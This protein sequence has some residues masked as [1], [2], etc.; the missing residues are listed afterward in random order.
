MLEKV[1]LIGDTHFGKV[2][3]TG[4]P[5]ERRGEI[6]E[7]F[8]EKFEKELNGSEEYV[9][10]LGDLFDNV[11]VSFGTILRVYN[12]IKNASNSNKRFYFIRGNHDSQRNS[13]ETSAF[14]I[15][16][17]MFLNNLNVNFVT[18][19]FYISDIKSLLIGW[20]YHNDNSEKI[21]EIIKEEKPDFVLGHF[22]EVL[23][24]YLFSYTGKVYSGHI[25]NAHKSGN[26][27]Y[28]GSL[29]P[30]AFGEESDDSLMMTLTLDEFLSKREDEIKDKRIRVVLKEGETL[31]NVRNCL[32][33]VLQNV[34]K[35]ENVKLDV[36]MDS[37]DMRQLFKEEL[38]EEIFEEMYNEYVGLL[39]C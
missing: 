39:E 13:L 33:L 32:Q 17:V 24:D 16:S 12:L 37:F 38:P 20:D 19:Y 36:E 10:H 2:F 29:L 25:H 6:E 7:K 3:K 5:Y 26:T 22:D 35:E 21:E 27:T 8:Y 14:D 1:K 34:K 28:V 30:L 11:V 9:I 23:P 18:D 31:Q 15:L 4:V